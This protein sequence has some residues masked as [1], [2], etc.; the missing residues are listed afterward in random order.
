MFLISWDAEADQKDLFA[1]P[2]QFE[3][4][5]GHY[6]S[7]LHSSDG[8]EVVDKAKWQKRRQEIFTFW[9]KTLGP[10]PPLL[11]QPKVEVLAS[12]NRD[13]VL[14]QQLRIEVAPNSLQEA[15]L[16]IPPGP[17]NFPA[18]FVPYY[19]PETSVG[20]N[21]NLL[22][23]F[24]WQ[25]AKRGFVTL[26]IGSPGG[27][28]RKPELGEAR[29]QPLYFLAYVAANCATILANHPKVDPKRLGV[30]GHSYGG[31]WALF[32]A[33]FDERFACAAWSDPGTVFDE[34]RPNVNY[35][36]PWYLGWEPHKQR[37]PGIPNP[38]NPRTG[39]YKQLYE[40]GHDLHEVLALIAPRPFFISGGSEDPPDRW[41]AL[42]RVQEVY[43]L[44]GRTNYIGMSNREGHNPTA[45]SNEQIYSFF[46]RFLKD[47]R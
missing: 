47:K 15:Y 29:C 18:V 3:G 9:N 7:L 17:G 10:W 20:L 36:E 43:H 6:S 19:E 45:E 41:Q 39:A 46:E 26:S 8:E 1:T 37:R 24:A 23:D 2:P 4:K 25:L 38:D 31:K 22:R 42:N 32:A 13:G 28:A 12:T 16:L 35:W 27:D 21:N 33:A 34:S 30:V 11:E 40:S 5:F 44:L 14:Q